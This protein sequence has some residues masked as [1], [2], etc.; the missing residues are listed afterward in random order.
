MGAGVVLVKKLCWNLTNTTPAARIL[1]A[2][3]FLFL[4]AHPPLNC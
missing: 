4:I 1:V 2:S 3:Q